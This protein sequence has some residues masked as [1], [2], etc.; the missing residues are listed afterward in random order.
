MRKDASEENKG[1][2]RPLA[3]GDLRHRSL[4]SRARNLEAGCHT[5]KLRENCPTSQAWHRNKSKLHRRWGREGIWKRFESCKT[6]NNN[7]GIFISELRGKEVMGTLRKCLI[8]TPKCQTIPII[9]ML[10]SFLHDQPSQLAW[11]FPV[12]ALKAPHPGKRL[13]P[14]PTGHLLLP[15]FVNQINCDYPTCHL[16]GKSYNNCFPIT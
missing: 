15:F 1:M 9:V 16:R 8:L 14:G 13:S 6:L 12:F 7:T 10:L 4:F 2:G 5:Y 3:S 11:D